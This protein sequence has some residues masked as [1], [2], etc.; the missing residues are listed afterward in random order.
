MKGAL[1]ILASFLV[2]PGVCCGGMGEGSNCSRVHFAILFLVVQY[3]VSYLF[4]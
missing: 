1:D 3:G 2:G 4:A